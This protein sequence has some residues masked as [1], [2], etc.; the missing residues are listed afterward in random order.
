[1]IYLFLLFSRPSSVTV[2]LTFVRQ[3]LVVFFYG[4]CS[5]ASFFF[6]VFHTRVVCFGSLL[7]YLF[8][9]VFVQVMTVGQ[10][11]FALLKQIA[12]AHLDNAAVQEQLCAAVRNLAS[13]D[14]NQVRRPDG[15]ARH[16]DWE[17]GTRSLV[18]RHLGCVV[19][20]VA[21]LLMLVEV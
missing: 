12:A 13:N 11:G 20:F 8:S 5:F 4:P 7:T 2:L 19:S 9:L 6:G 17:W 18:F 21:L 3:F 15:V 1:M 16:G 10:G 14:N